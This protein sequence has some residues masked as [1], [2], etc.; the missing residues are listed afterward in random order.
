MPKETTCRGICR[1]LITRFCDFSSV[2]YDMHGGCLRLQ[3]LN[4]LMKGSRGDW[5]WEHVHVLLE[6]NCSG[7]VYN[8]FVVTEERR[9]ETEQGEGGSGGWMCCCSGL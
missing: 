4:C 8:Q 2:K 3:G 6:L 5:D 1:D 7:H 9:Q